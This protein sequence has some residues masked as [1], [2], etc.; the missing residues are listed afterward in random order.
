MLVARLVEGCLAGQ[1][2]D[3]A[4]AGGDRALGHDA[5]QRD[6][7]GAADVGA[8]AQLDRVGAAV[9]RLAHR[10]DADLVAVLLAEQRHGAGA[11]S[12]RRGP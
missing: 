4:D 12:P 1:G 2:L 9:R 3:A 10:D 8:A 11:R 6:V 7:A 5:E